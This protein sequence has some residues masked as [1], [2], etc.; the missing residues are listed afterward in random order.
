ME[1]EVTFEM[2]IFNYNM[3]FSNYLLQN[4]SIYPI[5]II[6][7]VRMD[8]NDHLLHRLSIL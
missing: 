6:I 4:Y 2:C 3:I 1:I 8:T 5:I 7:F